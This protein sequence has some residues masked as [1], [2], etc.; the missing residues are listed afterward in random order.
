MGGATGAAGSLLGALL[1]VGAIVLGV[2]MTLLVSRLLSQTVLR[3]TPSSFTLE[4]PPYRSP[5]VGKVIVRS[6]MDRTLRV[7][8]RAVATAAPAGLVIWLLANVT[9]ADGTAVLMH[10]TRFFDPFARLLGMDG[11]IFTAFL[12]G[13]PANELVVPL[14][15]M[16]YTA[17][18][19]LVSLEGAALGELLIQNGWT[20][21]TALCTVLF[22]LFHWPC[23][24]TCL[25]IKKETQSVKWTLLSFLI[26]TVCGLLLC[27]FAATVARLLPG[28]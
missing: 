3:G 20:W 22:M 13:F 7:L 10:V 26:P 28:M 2:C 4:L 6:I 15:V 24:T 19:G 5:Q 9:T 11:T 17:Q 21:V 8:G 16:T 12:L 1:L 18:G 27:F 14:I 25:T 23:A